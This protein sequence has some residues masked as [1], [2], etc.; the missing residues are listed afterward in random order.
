[1]HSVFTELSDVMSR[2]YFMY[3]SLGKDE[4]V[5][6]IKKKERLAIY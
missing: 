3:N 4:E 5:R 6:V 2:M 1:M